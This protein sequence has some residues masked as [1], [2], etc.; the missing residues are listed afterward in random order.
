MNNMVVVLA[1]HGAPATD[2]PTRRVGILMALE[3]AGG[4]AAQSGFLGRWKIKLENE[5]RTWPRTDTNDPYKA[6]VDELAAALTE[7]TGYQVISSYNEFCSPTIQEAIDQA[8]ARG[9]TCVLVTPTMLLRG[10]QHTE[11]EIGQAVDEARQRHP[12]AIIQYAWPFQNESL[13]NLLA[14]HLDRFRPVL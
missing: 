3:F 12:T 13:V 11:A 14:E 9:A 10:N 1:A 5:I 7:R 2:Y 4:K 6:A 8:V